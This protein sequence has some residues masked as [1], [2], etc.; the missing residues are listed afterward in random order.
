MPPEVVK[1][2]EA[3]VLVLAGMSLVSCAVCEEINSIP[4]S[5]NDLGQSK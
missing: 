3:R 5:V 4:L 1:R 2:K